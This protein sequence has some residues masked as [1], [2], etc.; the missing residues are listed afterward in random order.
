MT[1]QGYPQQAREFFMAI[2]FN[3]NREFFQENREW[4]LHSVRE[5]SLALAAALSET[6]E[7]IDPRMDVRP[8]RALS[9]INRDV[10]FSR[11][12]SPY[13]D[14]VWIAFRRPGVEKG[15][16]LSFYAEVDIDGVFFGMGFY[17]QNR[18]LMDALRARMRRAPDQALSLLAPLEGDFVMHGERFRRMAVPEELPEGLRDWYLR[19]S[20]YLEKTLPFQQAESGALAGTIA[21][22]FMRLKPLYDY[23]SACAPEEEE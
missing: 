18:P 19:K 13:R 2:R 9:R 11:D 14:H 23:V 20:F 22:G 8:G 7:K 4:Y 15:K 5:P 17:A 10:R 1:F 12:K 6:V 21:A 16:S 3:N